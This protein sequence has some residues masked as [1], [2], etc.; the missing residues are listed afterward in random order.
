VSLYLLHIEPRYRHAGHYLGFCQAERVDRRV[1]EHLSGGSKASPLILA[2]LMAGRTVT[3]ARRWEGVQ[4]DRKAE[5]AKKGRGHT[6][7][8]PLCR[9]QIQKGGIA[10]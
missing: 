5:R 6:R 1:N 2:A 3:L 9:Q 10:P 7:M 8:C 4:Y